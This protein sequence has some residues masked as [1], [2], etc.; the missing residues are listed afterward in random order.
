M[1]IHIHT[2]LKQIHTSQEHTVEK[3]RKLKSAVQDGASHFYFKTMNNNTFCLRVKTETSS[4][5][6]GGCPAGS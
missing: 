5:P 1:Y 3:K 6:S 4:G 2:D